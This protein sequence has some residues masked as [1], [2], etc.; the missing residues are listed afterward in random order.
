MK[1]LKACVSRDHISDV[2]AF[3]TPGPFYIYIQGL[4]QTLLSKETY[5]KHICH[6]K[7]KQYMAVGT[8]RMFMEPSAAL[9]G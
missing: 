4:K 9:L 2:I 6:K 1:L 5:N 7:V 3:P 8:I